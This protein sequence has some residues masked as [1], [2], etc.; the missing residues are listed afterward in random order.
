MFSVIKTDSELLG[1]DWTVTLTANCHFCKQSQ[2]KAA[3]A[4]ALWPLEG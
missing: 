1:N 4:G 2:V 3:G